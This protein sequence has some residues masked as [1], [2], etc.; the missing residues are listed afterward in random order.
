MKLIITLIATLFIGT[1]YYNV[2]TDTSISID[3]IPASTRTPQQL[4]KQTCSYKSADIGQVVGHGADIH[5]AR[6]SASKICF[7][8]RIDLFERTRNAFPTTAQGQ[9]IIDSCVNI[10]CN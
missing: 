10:K 9:L 4:H 3:R 6:S 2:S 7:E 1:T 8:K 5:K